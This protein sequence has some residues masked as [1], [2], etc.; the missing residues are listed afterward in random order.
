MYITNIA[1]AIRYVILQYIIQNV[2]KI[3]ALRITSTSFSVEFWIQ[4]S[5]TG[6]PQGFIKQ[7]IHVLSREKTCLFMQ[8]A[9]YNASWEQKLAF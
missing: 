2:V 6:T 9:I 5:N 3:S 4:K 1:C 8:R 7:E